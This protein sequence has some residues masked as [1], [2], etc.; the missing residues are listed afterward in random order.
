ESGLL[1]K[2]CSQDD[3]KTIET[4]DILAVA[5]LKIMS[6]SPHDLM[7]DG[8]V[9]NAEQQRQEA[10]TNYVRL[11]LSEP[12]FDEF[13]ITQPVEKSK[14]VSIWWWTKIIS[15]CIIL[16]AFL[17]VFVIWGIPVLVE[18]VATKLAGGTISSSTGEYSP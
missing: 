15:L 13:E 6:N 17:A 3:L 11:G 10:T 1:Q 12:E 9:V 16:L 8:G 18:K 14:Y 5:T 4:R 7:R 2:F